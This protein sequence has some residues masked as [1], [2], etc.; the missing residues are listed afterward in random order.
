MA[1]LYFLVVLATTRT[2]MPRVSFAGLLVGES[3]RLAMFACLDGWVLTG[4]LVVTSL[5]PVPELLRRNQSPRL[6]LLHMALFAGLLVGGMLAVEAGAVTAG[7]VLLVGAVLVRSGVFP[8]HLWIP[9]LFERASFATALLTV[10]PIVGVYAGLRLVLPVAPDAVLRGIGAVSLGT[11]LYSAGMAVV[12]T[13]ARRFFAYLLLS[14]ASLVLVGLELHT[15]LSMTG[16]LCLW[17]SVML[18]LGGLGLTLRAL[19]SRFG[20]MSLSEY[21][22]LFDAS[23]ELAVCFLLTGLASVG[24]PGTLGF[25]SAEL[26]VDGTVEANL[27]LGVAVVLAAAINGIAIVRAYFLLFTGRRHEPSF[28]LA[29]TPRE[30]VAVLTLAALIF[31][32]GLAPQPGVRTRYRAAAEILAAR[33]EPAPADHEGEGHAE[34]RLGDLFSLK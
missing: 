16:A 18:S 32:G 24:F 12:Q 8:A 30:R 34:H 7:S 14:H 17:F 31:G 13:D 29:I 3:L 6:Y 20:R 21:H 9:D 5:A 27:L 15:L 1:L 19:E 33:G 25:I 23:P 10:V 2:K 28:P 26:L 22:G 4:L 11:A